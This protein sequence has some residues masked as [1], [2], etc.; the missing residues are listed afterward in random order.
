VSVV[1]LLSGVGRG[2]VWGTATDD[3]N[4]TVLVWPAGHVVDEH[5]N[6]V[7][8]VLLVVLDGGGVVRVDEASHE[9]SAGDALVLPRGA[10]RAIAAGADGIRY[11]TVHR[12]RGGL[13]IGRFA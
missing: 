8:D 4:A 12:R 6:D 10:L 11:L 5:V 7:C 1:H 3:L 13:E 9:V 2:P